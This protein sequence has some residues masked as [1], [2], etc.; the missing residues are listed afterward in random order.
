MKTVN[1]RRN[2]HCRG[3]SVRFRYDKKVVP[4]HGG[5]KL[6]CVE[7][8]VLFAAGIP[9]RR[10]DREGV[11]RPLSIKLPHASV[12]AARDRREVAFT[13]RALS[14]EVER[15]ESM[16][17]NDHLSKCFTAFVFTF[18]FDV[19][20]F[21]CATLGRCDPAVTGPVTGI[22]IARHHN[23]G[24]QTPQRRTRSRLAK[25]NVCL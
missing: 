17:V 16:L 9:P 1:A 5:P 3:D 19:Q 23:E 20:T 7:A 14:R 25:I 11:V 8:M 15:G 4:F 13:L 24:N 18:A 6:V 10:A 22:F 12:K 21:T 2:L